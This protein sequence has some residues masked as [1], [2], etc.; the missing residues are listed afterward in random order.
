MFEITT[1]ERNDISR[2]LKKFIKKCQLAI[3]K[4]NPSIRQKKIIESLIKEAL[5]IQKDLAK[6]ENDKAI[7]ILALRAA[8]LMLKTLR[9]L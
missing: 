3:E 5:S 8:I 9:D 7:G 4:E 2:D 1:K 6:T